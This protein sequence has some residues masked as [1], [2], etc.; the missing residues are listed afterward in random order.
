M[1]PLALP[2]LRDAR[3]IIAEETNQEKVTAVYQYICTCGCI[4]R[5]DNHR[6]RLIA[7]FL[8]HCPEWSEQI[9]RRLMHTMLDG[10]DDNTMGARMQPGDYFTDPSG[11]IFHFDGTSPPR[12][13]TNRSRNPDATVAPPQPFSD[14]PHQMRQ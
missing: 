11:D 9:E 1:P 4:I 6:T 3:R 14:M 7:Q 12:P 10:T 13:I 8:R 2:R 5:S